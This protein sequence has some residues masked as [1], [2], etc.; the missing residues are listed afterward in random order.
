MAIA[1]SS[2]NTLRRVL[3]RLAA[4]TPLKTERK[5]DYYRRCDFFVCHTK[6]KAYEVKA[7]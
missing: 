2:I 5:W 3:L 6:Y 7:I 4:Y 1:G